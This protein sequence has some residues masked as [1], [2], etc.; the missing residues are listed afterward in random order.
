MS[1]KKDKKKQSKHDTVSLYPLKFE[2]A[3][4]ELLG[5]DIKL[6]KENKNVKHDSKRQD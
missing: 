2:E 5:V 4:K 1:L 3:M 6:E